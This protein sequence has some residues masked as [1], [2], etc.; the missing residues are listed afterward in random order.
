MKKQHDELI[1]ELIQL[2]QESSRRLK[3]ME[4][5]QAIVIPVYAILGLSGLA[6][7]LKAFGL[8]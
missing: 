7:L 5:V 3:I 8:F 4:N 1:G 6:A 2:N